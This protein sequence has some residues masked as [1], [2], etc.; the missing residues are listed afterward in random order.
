MAGHRLLRLR[1]RLRFHSMIPVL[2]NGGPKLLGD[3]LCFRVSL[4][5]TSVTEW[6]MDKATICVMALN[7]S[8]DDT[9]VTEWR[10]HHLVRFAKKEQFH[11]MIP[12]LL[13]GGLLFPKIC[14]NL[15]LVSLDDTSVT[16]WRLNCSLSYPLSFSCFTR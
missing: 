13:N 16:E 3:F 2:L 9:S 1:R 11:S 7:V 14:S 15:V 6:R 4:D 10:H 5:D 8:L 12:V